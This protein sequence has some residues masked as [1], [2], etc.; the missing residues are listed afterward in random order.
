MASEDKVD[1]TP[2]TSAKAPEETQTQVKIDSGMHQLKSAALGLT[3]SQ[4]NN[5]L[6]DTIN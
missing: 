2:E 5:N 6:V 1:Q 3:Q 4:D